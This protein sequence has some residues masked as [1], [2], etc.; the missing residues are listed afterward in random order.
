[1][2]VK[3]IHKS[4]ND[5]FIDEHVIH[6]NE[7]G[8]KLS[9]RFSGGGKVYTYDD[10]NRLI[11][12]ERS[13]HSEDPNEWEVKYADI[14]EYTG[15]NSDFR[16]TTYKI[17]ARAINDDWYPRNEI[18]SIRETKF[19]GHNKILDKTFYLRN[20]ENLEYSKYNY[21]NNEL[22]YEEHFKLNGTF[23]K[24]EYVNNNLILEEQKDI[25]YWDG[26][27]A[28]IVTKTTYLYDDKRV[29]E[30]ARYLNS[31]HVYTIRNI[32]LKN[33][34]IKKS[35][36]AIVEGS[37]LICKYTDYLYAENDRLIKKEVYEFYKGKE[38]LCEYELFEYEKNQKTIKH[39]T[40]QEYF[41]LSNSSNINYS[42]CD[43][44]KF[45]TDEFRSFGTKLES[46]EIDNYM[47]T[48]DEMFANWTFDRNW[49]KT[50]VWNEQ[51]DV[52][53]E[54]YIEPIEAIENAITSITHYEYNDEGKL[55]FALELDLLGIMKK[56]SKY[57]Y[58]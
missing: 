53:K 9:E 42:Q 4:N 31:V 24:K 6:Y 25:A 23:K 50:E 7:A 28:E 11:R 56:V 12:V 48:T 21:K 41:D 20:F 39:Y 40:N 10:A 5:H 32:Y 49:Q 52:I 27:L 18:I 58:S 33:V 45:W 44:R 38:I 8:L 1:M 29:I 46:T 30:Q 47:L 26:N 14:Y 16:V 22:I 15:A 37:E 43:K 54:V 19:S 55:E 36:Y 3:E 51:G 57:Y 17:E 34:L 35:E 13:G 2:L